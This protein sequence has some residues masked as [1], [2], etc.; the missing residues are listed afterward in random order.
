MCPPSGQA[1]LSNSAIAA[2]HLPITCPQHESSTGSSAS[3]CPC[4]TR[5]C[6]RHEG[7]SFLF[8]SSGLMPAQVKKSSMET[9]LFSRSVSFSF[10]ALN[11]V[12]YSTQHLSSILYTGLLM[13]F[14]I[15]ASI[16]SLMSSISTISRSCSLC[17]DWI[18]LSQYSR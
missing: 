9:S 5:Y 2:H 1:E 8:V 13:A 7:Q 10:L 16:H 11:P 3:C 18:G 4:G 12:Q 17:C 15:S 14:S 6:W